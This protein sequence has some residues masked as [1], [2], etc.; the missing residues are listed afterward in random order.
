M[1]YATVKTELC[2]PHASCCQLPIFK[3]DDFEYGSEIKSRDFNLGP[4]DKL[5]LTLPYPHRHDCYQ[6]VWVAQGTGSHVIDSILYEVK[7]KTLFFMSPGQVH[8]F[9]LSKDT[10]GC[11]INFSQ[12][13]FALQVQ[14][15]NVFNDIPIYDLSNSVQ[16]LYLDSE[17]ANSVIETLS[18]METEYYS[19]KL[20]WQDVIRCHLYILLMKALRT[21]EPSCDEAPTAPNLYLTRRFKRL[22]EKQFTTIQLVSEYS[23]L[24]RV[25]ERVLNDAVRQT[26]GSTAAKMIRVRVI[27]EA[28]RMMLHSEVSV[29]EV[30]DQLSFEDPAYF[31]RCFKKHTGLSPIEFRRSLIKK[32]N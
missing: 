21:V 32:Q 28:K 19:D 31:S 27:L 13:F 9:V 5:M 2:M 10:L 17:E 29:A 11:T 22:L 30:A 23:S 4:L 15:K 3:I 8:D 24:L 1:E 26:T 6:I 16:A 14:N 20:G 25:S 7:P 12:E 18:A